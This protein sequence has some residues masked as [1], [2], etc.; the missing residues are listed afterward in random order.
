MDKISVML[1]T[2]NG[3]Q[4]LAHCLESIKWADE[5]V[6]IDSGSS[7]GSIELIKKYT[8]NYHHHDWPGYL[9]Q[10]EYGMTKC[11]GEWILI[12]DQDEYVTDELRKKLKEIFQNTEKYSS[13]NAGWIRRI[14]HFWGKRIN[15]GNYNP[16]FQPRL[17]RKGKCRWTGFAHTWM[18]VEGGEDKII[19]INEPL[20]HD[21]YNTPF[22][23]FNK[24]NKYSELDVAER[25]P[26]GY[27]PGILRVV[28]SPLAMWWKCYIV[29]RGFMDGAHGLMNANS[30]M[31]Y[32]FFRLAKAWHI[33]WLG[34]NKPADWENYNRLD[35]DKI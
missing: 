23:Y 12:L 22:D 10:R 26:E 18:E 25:L 34:K 29:H 9:A 33:R 21:S 32:W 8:T 27:N 4:K 2:F 1:N 24:I 3:G 30:M 5:I 15:H 7:D 31:V 17:A 14:E 28:F 6:V 13:F 20:W 19:R 35:E 11:S 16:S